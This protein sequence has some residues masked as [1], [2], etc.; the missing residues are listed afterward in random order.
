M[1]RPQD[2]PLEASVFGELRALLTR[3]F[4]DPREPDVFGRVDGLAFDVCAAGI[5]DVMKDQTQARKLLAAV[6]ASQ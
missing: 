5:K 2:Q 6:Q 3:E 4:G 1:A